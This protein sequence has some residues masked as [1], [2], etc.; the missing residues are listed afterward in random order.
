MDT[1]VCIICHEKDKNGVEHGEFWQRPSIHL[2][3]HGCNKCSIQKH[4][5]DAVFCGV[6]D[7]R[8]INSES[9]K[10]PHQHWKEM[11]KRCYDPN[12]L[13]VHPTY[14]DC[15]VCDEWLTYS[16][17][18]CW[19]DDNYM[20]GY[21]L[22]KDILVKG[23][24]VYSPDTCCFVPREINT[25]FVKRQNQRGD[26]PIGVSYDKGRG[27]Y[28]SG[29]TMRGKRIALG[30]FLTSSEAFQ[31]YK[32]AKEAYIK[33]VANEYYSDGRITK[34]VYDALMRYEVEITD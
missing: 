14:N 9:D 11:I 23:N 3:G 8:G 19:F 31:A 16:T 26:Y 10:K 2:S 6:I 5:V 25:L 13:K 22:D 12:N 7:K 4:M 1:E 30:R 29:L 17:F 28:A 21:Q 24:K 34:R 15:S 20:E 27:K 32:T 18:K 33:E